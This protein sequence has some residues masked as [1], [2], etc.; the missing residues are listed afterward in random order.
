MH[1]GAHSPVPNGTTDSNIVVQSSDGQRVPI[2]ISNAKIVG[3]K[4]VWWE[5]WR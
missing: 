4:K 1:L 5:I 2:P 3:F